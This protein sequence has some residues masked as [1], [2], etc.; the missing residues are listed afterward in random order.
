MVPSEQEHDVPLI[1]ADIVILEKEDFVDSI[2]LKCAGFDKQ[3]N[4]AG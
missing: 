4:R 3:A 1:G 2:F